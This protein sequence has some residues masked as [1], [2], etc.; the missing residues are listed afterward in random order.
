M[1][2]TTTRSG[3]GGRLRRS[4]WRRVRMGPLPSP[5]GTVTPRSRQPC[6]GDTATTGVLGKLRPTH[7]RAWLSFHVK[8]RRILILMVMVVTFHVK[9][10]EQHRRVASAVT[11]H[12]KRSGSIQD[13]TLRLRE[14]P[15]KHCTSSMFGSRV[16][17]SLVRLE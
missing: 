11:F 4:S 9:H 8:Q 15:S 12:V 5:T 13:R 3:E 2:W 1:G 7:T 14:R 16:G 17:R 10:P 6:Q